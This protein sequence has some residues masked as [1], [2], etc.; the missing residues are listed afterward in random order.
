MATRISISLAALAGCFLL[1]SAA[2]ADS[3]FRPNAIKYKDSSLSHAT[4]RAGNATMDALALLGKD[5]TTELTVTAGGGTLQKVQ[6]KLP[7][8]ST[9]NYSNLS[10]ATF[11]QTFTGLAPRSPLGLQVNVDDGARTGVISA[12]ETVKLRPDLKIESAS[13]PPHTAVGVPFNVTALVRE[14]NGDLGARASCVLLA[15]G[16]EVDR[17]EGIWVDARGAV[18]CQMTHMFAAAGTPQ[19]SVALADARPADYDTANDRSA[20]VAVQVYADVTQLMPWSADAQERTYER[21]YFSSSPYGSVDDSWNGWSVG[22]SL[23]SIYRAQTVNVETL[24]ASVHVE[25]DGQTLLDAPDVAFVHQSRYDWDWDTARDCAF[26]YFDRD[27]SLFSACRIS[28]P[29][30]DPYVTVAFNY[31]AGDATYVSRGWYTTYA[32]NGEPVDVHYDRQTREQYGTPFHL[33]DT[34]SFRLQFSDGAAY[35]DVNPSMTL[36]PFAYRNEQP[37]TCFGDWCSSSMDASSGKQGTDNAA[38]H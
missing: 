37:L 5:G 21:R 4:G 24:R 38:N 7:G 31:N 14:T 20:A 19:I 10:G 22:L 30:F 11:T 16:V 18:T 9:Q 26:G 13:I 36:Q 29:F 34:A 12:T 23:F 2:L 27:N 3:P 33:G 6:V 32:A 28:S 15:D 35:W 25:T 1:T 17:A 8:D